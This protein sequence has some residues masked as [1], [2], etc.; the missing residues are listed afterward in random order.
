[1][2]AE[3]KIQA[4]KPIH[5][6]TKGTI[7]QPQA[8]EQQST[9]EPLPLLLQRAVLEADS[10][11]P[12]DANRLQQT[13]GNQ[14]V[15]HLTG[16]K[17]FSPAPRV[18]IQ[19]KLTLG[20][21]GDKYEQ[22]ADAVAKQVVNNLS[23]QSS[24]QRQE[25]EEMLQ[26]KP[27]VQRQEEEEML[28]TK[29]VVQRHEE[30]EML[31]TKPVVQRDEEEEMLQTKPVVQRQEEEEMLQTK[32]VVQRQEEEEMLQMKPVVQR[33]EE[34]EMLQ[35]KA[36][37][38]HQGGALSGEV[39]TAVT[40]A[41][42][43]GQPLADTIRAPM[44]RAFNSDFGQVKVHTDGQADHL[45][46]SIQA[47]AF[48][49]GQDIFFRQG[50]YSPNTSGGQELLAHELTHVVQQGGAGLQRKSPETI[51]RCP[52]CSGAVE[53]THI[54][55]KAVD[56]IQRRENGHH[57]GCN[58]SACFGLQRKTDTQVVMRHHEEEM[59]QA[60][61]PSAGPQPAASP[62]ISIQHQADVYQSTI[63]RH[64][65]WEHQLLG[66]VPPDKLAMLG[67][68]QD[69]ISQTEEEGHLWWAKPKQ[70]EASIDIQGVGTIKKG[71]I[72]HVLAQ[73]LKRLSDWQ[74]DPP[75]GTS[76]QDKQ[77]VLGKHPAWDV[78]LVSLPSEGDKDPLIVTY[79]EL[80]TL[81]D[82]YGDLEAMKTANPKHR[83]QIVQS[84]RQETFFRLKDIYE[85]ISK[86]LTKTEKKDK[87]VKSAQG[88]IKKGKVFDRKRAGFK[89][90]G[91]ITPDYI[92]GVKGQ[93]ELLKGVQST[94]TKGKTN[95]YGAT[96]ARNACHFVPESWHAW[97]HYHNEGR[98]QAKLSYDLREE[99]KQLQQQFDQTDFSRRPLDQSEQMIA[100]K[101]KESAADRA[102][103]EALL[104]NG[105][106]DHYLQD[107]YAS[108]HMLNK[109]QIMQ[110]YVQYIDQSNEWD[111]FKDK[112]WRKVQ[113]MAYRQ[114]GLASSDQ[115]TKDKVQ[116][117]QS[118]ITPNAP[119]NPQNVEN[120]KDQDW[121]TRFEALGLQVPT[122]LQTAGS[123]ERRLMEWWQSQGIN[124]AR[125]QSGQDLLDNNP[126][127]S[128]PA[129][130]SALKN[131]VLDGI[132][133]IDGMP[134]EMRGLI[135]SG[136]K[137][138]SLRVGKNQGDGLYISKGNKSDF[139]QFTD[140]KF[141]L[142]NDYV[143]KDK[144]RF[145]KALKASK[146]G[147]D[148][149]YQRMAAS[150]TYGDY[151]E[152]MKSGFIQ[153]ATNA[154][155]DTFCKGGLKV[156]SGDGQQVFKVY[157]DDAM[158]NEGSAE[159]VKHS[160]ET[161]NMS[162]DSILNVTEHGDDQGITAKSIVDRLPADVQVDVKDENGM[163]TGTAKTSIEKWHNPNNGPSLKQYCFDSVF[164][165]MS[166]SLVQKFAPGV[167][168]SE[169]GTISK[170]ENVHGSD[171]F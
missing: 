105:F 54:Q 1:M 37:S 10:I 103:N 107:S 144:K 26:M 72:M 55:A 80:N 50:E 17:A 70:K 109:T 38:M 124:D 155:H 74:V 94:G 121:L 135:M 20:P 143:P 5:I 15:G 89:F 116:G 163:V 123:N 149:Q 8:P 90:K 145:R 32:P 125:E 150:V 47:R 139:T 73:E 126:I 3:N 44:E 29:P 64:S 23:Q 36:D 57:H 104:N 58:C 39:E 21:V 128:S 48:T 93:I 86:S 112:N 140:V 2:S 119:R 148:S 28:Q 33:D 95:E 68:W 27:V 30:E 160:G 7:P 113:Q 114:P 98:K 134:V 51:C 156:Y 52:A 147:D 82:F 127:K 40:Q 41:K 49:T 151:F 16:Q 129:L 24:M 9:V 71:N 99:A 59:A 158:F 170:D 79:G 13:I 87:D 42:S 118:G 115:Y 153:K 69:L 65:S 46:R 152:F 12:A 78:V 19:P 122:S 97:A 110:W 130:E 101:L 161:A 108:G 117:V 84:V 60:K 171:A 34:E 166:W 45:N 159:G 81:A 157:G 136:S 91:A 25:E 63:Q 75:K 35:G 22:E 96:L 168:G 83:W 137:K 31:Q 53:E 165:G 67:T 154:L 18:M 142:R 138:L 133:R 100:I 11:S 88:I 132:V 146:S 111:Y 162:R 131:L 164:P 6:A 43:G 56:H 102:A 85:Q 169:L 92:S 4:N 106:G 61:R 62:P 167:L 141:I 76:E 120:N 77:K 14:A 66:D